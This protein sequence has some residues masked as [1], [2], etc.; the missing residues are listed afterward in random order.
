MDSLLGGDLYFWRVG[1][2]SKERE[3]DD[4]DEGGCF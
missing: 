3:E 1:L 4:D 2:I